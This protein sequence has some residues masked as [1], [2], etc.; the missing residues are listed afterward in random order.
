MKMPILQFNMTIQCSL[1]A[2]LHQRYLI[3]DV[4]LSLL[5]TVSRR[6]IIL[7]LQ[8]LWTIIEY[9]V[10]SGAINITSNKENIV[11]LFSIAFDYLLFLRLLY[12]HI[13]IL[14]IKPSNQKVNRIKMHIMKLAISKL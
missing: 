4:V 2:I 8:R 7:Q 12:H 9:R 10:M 6:E 5:L 1:S 14:I 3:Y 11:K 13:I